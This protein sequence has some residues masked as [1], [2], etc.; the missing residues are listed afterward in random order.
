MRAVII[1]KSRGHS[2]LDDEEV[3]HHGA[4]RHDEH[5]EQ[6]EAGT[7]PA[8]GVAR[9]FLEGVHGEV[10]QPRVER[11]LLDEQS[12]GFV[13]EYRHEDQEEHARPQAAHPERVGYADD[14]RSDDRVDEVR[15]RAHYR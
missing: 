6:H 8:V 7:Y 15:R 9:E 5:V 4:V 10:A 1:A 3:R 11:G 14:T 2:V 12:E 13:S